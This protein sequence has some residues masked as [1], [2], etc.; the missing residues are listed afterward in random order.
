MVRLSTRLSTRNM[1]PGWARTIRFDLRK[2]KTKHRE[3]TSSEVWQKRDSRQKLLGVSVHC[4]AKTIATN[5]G[6]T[7]ALF[8]FVEL[9]GHNN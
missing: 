8:M 9:S 3:W 1:W 5:N 2:D 7:T 6:L 4:E